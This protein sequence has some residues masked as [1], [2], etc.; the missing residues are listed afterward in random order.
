[1]KLNNPQLLR[2]ASYI[3]GTWCDHGSKDQVRN[4]AN[5]LE[6]AQVPHHGQAECQQAIEAAQQALSAWRQ[7]S[8]HE[9]CAI[10]KRWFTLIMENQ[11]DLAVI[12]TSEQGK[13]LAEAQGEVAYGANFIE[14]FAEEAKR[15]YGELI[16][17]KTAQQRI[18]V[19]KQG[20][21]VVAA[22]TPWNFP[23]AMI[24][25]KCAPALAA[26]C[27]VVIKPA[28]DTPL[29]AL[30]LCALA[31]EAGFPPGVI[32]CITGD[33]VAIGNEL[34]ANPIVK[35]L[36][37]TGSTAVGKLLLKQCADT[38]KKVSLE[39]GGNAPF[40]VFEDANIDDAVAGAMASKFRNTGQTCVCTN[41]FYV[42]EKVH[43]QFCTA[44]S[45]AIQALQVGDG[46]SKDTQQGPLINQ[47]A[48]AKV[49]AHVA[50]ACEKGATLVCG[51]KAHANG[52]TFFEPTLLTGITTEMRIS[53]EETFG[54]VAG[55]STFSSD[56]EVIALANNTNSGLASYIYTNDLNRAITVSE[57]LEYGMVGVND[58]IISNEVAPFG[59]I[60]ESG[61]GREGSHYGIDDFVEL[62]YVMLGNV[63]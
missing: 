42:H 10:M 38:V 21:G 61:L 53:Q 19:M 24:T 7:C 59:G 45:R 12:M 22:I 3:N 28:P 63:K 50:D 46:F 17:G 9:R 48:L 8:A 27:T 41:R 20:I 4:P 58:G 40:I 29:S 2:T 32:N 37:F 6:I 15:I 13:P 25:R 52:G 33:A 11:D 23:H 57:K 49:Q 5:G 14:W 60:K 62:K 36:S 39:L 16:P 43:D 30:A 35:K 54:P 44:F 26:G 1:M 56:E 51:G 31:E 47:A 55:V 34:C 18:M